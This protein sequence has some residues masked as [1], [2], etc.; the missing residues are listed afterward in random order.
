MAAAMMFSSGEKILSAM[1]LSNISLKRQVKSG[2][3]MQVM[4]ELLVILAE[5]SALRVAA[6]ADYSPAGCGTAAVC[7]T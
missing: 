7:D 6:D 2:N 4:N 1:N 3:Q 5:N